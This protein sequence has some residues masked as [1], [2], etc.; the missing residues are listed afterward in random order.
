MQKYLV[1]AAFAASCVAS[2][3]TGNSAVYAWGQKGHQIINKVAVSM[4]NN[5]E[6]KQFIQA[7][8]AQI[9]AFASTPDTRWKSGASGAEEKPL[10]WFEIDGYSKSALGEGVADLLFSHAQQKLGGEFVTKYG[11]AMWRTSDLYAQLVTAL[12]QKDWSRAIQ[13]GGVMGHY[14][15]DMTQPMHATSDYDGQSIGKPGIHRYYETTLVDGIDAQHLYDNLLALAGEH[16]SGLERSIGNDL[17]NAELQ[18]VTY[19]EAEGAF[20]AMD[21]ITPQFEANR[22]N[23]QWLTDDLTPRLARAAALLGKVWDVAFVAAGA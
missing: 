16:R 21:Q 13:I 11:K 18:H 17:D 9:T 4:V 19:S 14:V 6:A 1:P 5:P 3:F 23:D 20:N 2:V 12:K 15:G 22:Y 7:N 8:Q 10:H